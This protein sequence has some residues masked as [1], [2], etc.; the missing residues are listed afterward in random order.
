[1]KGKTG[2]VI[3]ASIEMEEGLY[4]PYRSSYMTK[5]K[6]GIG[7]FK[8]L[9]NAPDMSSECKISINK[10]LL[11]ASAEYLHSATV[12]SSVLCCSFKCLNGAEC[13]FKSEIKIIHRGNGRAEMIR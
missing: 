2:N 7:D 4:S 8:H 5:A 12:C 6:D 10:M 13:A 1:M 11:C 3:T 9:Q